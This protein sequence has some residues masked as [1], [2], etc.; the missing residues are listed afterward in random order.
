MAL[1]AIKPGGT[2]HPIVDSF[3]ST[4]RDH[5][6]KPW[7]DENESVSNAPAERGS[8]NSETLPLIAVPSQTPAVTDSS[9]L[10]KPIVGEIEPAVTEQPH[11]Q[12]SRP[13]FVHP[14]EAETIA[15]AENTHALVAGTKNKAEAT[16]ECSREVQRTEFLR[17]EIRVVRASSQPSKVVSAGRNPGGFEPKT[18]R[19]QGSGPSVRE[20]DEIQIHIGRIEVTAV[21]PAPTPAVAKPQRNVPSLDEYLKR[22]DRRTS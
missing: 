14:V 6:Y 10:P 13:S 22:R 1:S 11:A 18:R 8:T 5:S 16:G 20:P 9:P 17:P 7:T 15:A 12:R 19:L 21:H 4:R 2:I 3:Y